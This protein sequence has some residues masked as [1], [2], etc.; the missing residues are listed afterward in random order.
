MQSK[1]QSNRPMR[2]GRS[3]L[4]E[5]E[6]K[7]GGSTWRLAV[8]LQEQFSA[9]NQVSKTFPRPFCPF[10]SSCGRHL[11]RS[12]TSSRN[13]CL[14]QF[15]PRGESESI[16]HTYFD[17]DHKN[18]TSKMGSYNKKSGE[19]DAYRPRFLFSAWHIMCRVR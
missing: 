19:Y 10:A 1:F 8:P 13:D 3:S 4:T 9:N 18:N 12:H 11:T 5:N 2:A 7:F 15:V 16:S 14:S 6:G 17:P